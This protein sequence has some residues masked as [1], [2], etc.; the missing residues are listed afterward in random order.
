MNFI[1]DSFK[2][3]F[4]RQLI[5]KA[6]DIVIELLIEFKRG[7]ENRNPPSSPHLNNHL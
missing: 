7:L 5:L 2:K 1:S 4:K 6:L 3:N